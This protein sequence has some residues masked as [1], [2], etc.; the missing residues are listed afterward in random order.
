MVPN[1]MPD[2]DRA[3]EELSHFLGLGRGGEI[4]IEMRMAEQRVTH[5]TTD[6]PGLEAGLLE[7]LGDAA[8]SGRR[9]DALPGV[10]L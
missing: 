10:D 6:A 5:R 1:S 7:P 8:D 4:P 9:I 2:R 3:L